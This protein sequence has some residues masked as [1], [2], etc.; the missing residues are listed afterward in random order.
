MYTFFLARKVYTLSKELYSTVK[1]DVLSMGWGGVGGAVQEDC[2]KAAMD[3]RQ[4]HRNTSQS[5]ADTSRKQSAR[6]L[7]NV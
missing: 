1:K 7:E 3:E 4:P 2:F 5:P 6:K